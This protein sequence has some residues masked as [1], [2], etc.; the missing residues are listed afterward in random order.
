MIKTVKFLRTLSAILFLGILAWV[1]AY[2]PY[3]VQLLEERGVFV[4]HK[5]HFFYYVGGAVLIINLFIIILSQIVEPLI[6]SKGG[7]RAMA[8]FTGLGFVLNIYFT[9]L[10]GFVGVLNNQA[11]VSVSGFAYLNYFGPVLLVG[12]IFGFFYFLKSKK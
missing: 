1:Y 7:E 2:L 4:I 10:V 6:L 12:W 3:Q 9:L 8:W 5:E 11:S